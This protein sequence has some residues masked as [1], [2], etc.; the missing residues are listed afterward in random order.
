MH[1]MSVSA[2]RVTGAATAAYV[3]DITVS[4]CSILLRMGWSAAFCRC[5]PTRPTRASTWCLRLRGT[6]RSLSSTG[7]M[8]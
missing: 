3:A 4:A 1:Q 6:W 2:W 5:P 7:I 8:H